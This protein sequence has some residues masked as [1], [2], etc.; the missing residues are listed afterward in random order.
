M[1]ACIYRF[2]RNERN[3]FKAECI[4]NKRSILTD[5][6]NSQVFADLFADVQEEIEEL[7]RDGPSKVVVT[8][9]IKT[10]T[11]SVNRIM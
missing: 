5:Q 3:V 1:Q 4:I 6:Y 2:Y 8:R 7:N 11:A 10:A 9:S